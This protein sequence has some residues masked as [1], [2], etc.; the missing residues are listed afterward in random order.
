MSEPL[1]FNDLMRTWV[2]K[3]YEPFENYKVTF[4]GTNIQYSILLVKYEDCED[5]KERI[6]KVEN[7]MK[8]L[9]GKFDPVS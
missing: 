4:I 7:I 8:I 5:L 3:G 2:G 9:N 1:I 6:S